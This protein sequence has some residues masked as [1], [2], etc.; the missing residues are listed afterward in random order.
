[1]RL[2][3]FPAKGKFEEEENGDEE[4]NREEEEKWQ[5][6]ISSSSIPLAYIK[7]EKAKS[8]LILTLGRNDTNVL[9]LLSTI[10]TSP[11]VL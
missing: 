8:K 11:I 4:K 10:K 9:Q 1:M 5:K 6:L 3:K 7:Q 2:Q